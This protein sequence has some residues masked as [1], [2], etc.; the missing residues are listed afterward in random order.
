[1]IRK[2]LIQIRHRMQYLTGDPEYICVPFMPEDGSRRWNNETN[3]VEEYDALRDKW[4]DMNTDYAGFPV[5]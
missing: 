2:A 4:V 5:P 1:M 3:T